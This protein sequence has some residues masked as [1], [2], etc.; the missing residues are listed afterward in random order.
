MYEMMSWSTVAALLSIYT[1]AA[2]GKGT[3]QLR[4]GS[5][6]R[7]WTIKSLTFVEKEVIF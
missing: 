7:R 2:T 5:K 3:N 4:T 6:V 1:T